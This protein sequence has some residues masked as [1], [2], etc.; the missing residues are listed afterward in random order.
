MQR[1]LKSFRAVHL[2]SSFLGRKDSGSKESLSLKRKNKA[3]NWSDLHLHFYGFL[4]VGPVL[5]VLSLNQ[6]L[7][8]LFFSAGFH[9]KR[10]IA[11][12]R[13][14]NWRREVDGQQDCNP[15]S[16]EENA[17]WFGIQIQIKI[18]IDVMSLTTF[19]VGS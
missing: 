8:L 16:W 19:D 11:K 14:E 17:M 3:L 2:L 15:G 12:D 9:L 5:D 6:H 13:G 7:L 4:I 10:A 1:Y 18:K